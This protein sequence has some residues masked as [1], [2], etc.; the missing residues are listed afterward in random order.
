MSLTDR[1]L[2]L[3]DRIA[4]L[5]IVA[6]MSGMVAVVSSQVLLRYAFNSSIDWADDI[7][8]LFFVWAVFLAMPI[9]VGRGAHIAIELLTTHLTPA[10][11]SAMLRVTSLGCAGMMIVVAWQAW[12]LICQQWDELM[13][14]VDLT[15]S[16]FMIPVAISAAHCALHLLA[17]AAR[18][19]ALRAQESAE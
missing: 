15:V 13:T 10:T 9:G 14:T 19:R 8:R 12:V 2:E 7:G 11:R 18:G 1:F 5:A 17:I 6:A 16:L 4:G 3:V